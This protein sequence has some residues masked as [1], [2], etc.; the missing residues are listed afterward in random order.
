[1]RIPRPRAGARI[2]RV[3]IGV[4][5]LAGTFLA[6]PI[7]PATGDP[8]V[9]P[10]SAS[11]STVRAQLPGVVPLIEDDPGAGLPGFNDLPAHLSISATEG[12]VTSSQRAVARR[13]KMSITSRPIWGA[14]YLYGHNTPVD[15]P[16]RYLPAC[17]PGLK[18]HCTPDPFYQPSCATDDPATQW[19]TAYSRHALYPIKPLE[20]GGAEVGVLIEDKINLIAFGTIPATAT[21]T[22]SVPRVNGAF[23]PLMS[24]LWD[25]KTGGCAP[26]PRDIPA[27]SALVEGKVII[28]LS[29]L[30]V[31][32]VPVDL[33]PRCR[34][35]RPAD[36]YLWG[37]AGS[38]NYFPSSGGPL[39]AFDGLHPGSRG[40]LNDPFYFE[41]NGRT[42]PPSSGVDIPPFV[43]CG[44]GGDDLSP[45]V[46]AMASGPN[47]PVRA[48]QGGL[49]FLN[50]IPLED[51]TMCTTGGAA[52]C[53]LPAPEAPPMPPLP[54]GEGE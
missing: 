52:R 7:G 43:N 49:V 19:R 20:G 3:A 37:D 53:P 32:G 41:D 13:S 2:G 6:L 40:P 23:R 12:T 9:G 24:H 25:R 31:D 11:Q 33:G 47:N 30:E 29:D 8:E 46:S 1:M 35:R 42:L 48:V 50:R 51:L 22:M 18:T 38:G 44:T 14:L 45:V 4:L 34:T 17:H 16:T 21:L 28:Q 39:G 5:L 54:D 36:V 26:R 10:L 27:V 15:N